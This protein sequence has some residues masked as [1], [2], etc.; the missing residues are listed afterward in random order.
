MAVDPV[1][2]EKR[3]TDKREGISRVYKATPPAADGQARITPGYPALI[4][5]V[6]KLPYPAVSYAEWFSYTA[7]D[8]LSE[9]M[10]WQR[11][12]RHTC[13]P[14]RDVAGCIV[15]DSGLDDPKLFA[16][17]DDQGAEF[18]IRARPDRRIAV[19][20]ERLD[21]WE[22]DES[23]LDLVDCMAGRVCRKLVSPTP[24]SSASVTQ[25]WTGFKLT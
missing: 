6:V 4:A 16:D 24:G 2:F 21:R 10:H 20:N 18:I 7:P 8:F 9:N 15:A 25:R 23:L 5:Q 1:N 12:I 11:A 17:I 22:T 19:Y 14:L 13:Q 3:Y